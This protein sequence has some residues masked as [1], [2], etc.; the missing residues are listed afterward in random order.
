MGSSLTCNKVGSIQDPGEGGEDGEADEGRHQH[1]GLGH[2]A[3]GLGHDRMT[4][5]DVSLHCQS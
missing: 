2:G 3:P 1:A 5:E 4:H